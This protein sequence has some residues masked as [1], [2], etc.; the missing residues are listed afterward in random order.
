[1][2]LSL[3]SLLCVALIGFASHR[4]SLCNVRAVVELMCCRSAFMLGCMARAMLWMAALASALVWLFDAPTA[5][6]LTQRSLFW[7]F[8][9]GL[10]F[11]VGAAVNGGCSLSSL[12]RLVNGELGMLLTLGGFAAGVGLWTFFSP[13][14]PTAALV[15]APS[16]W[17]QA[18]PLAPWAP[19]ALAAWALFEA[20]RLWKL[21]RSSAAVSWRERL[22][23][24]SYHLSVAA[25]LLGLS[26]GFLYA[27]EGAWSYTNYLRGTMG[28]LLGQ[29]PAPTPWHG[30]LVAALLL[31]MWLSAAQRRA[32]ALQPPRDLGQALRHL[33]AGLLMGAGAALIPG[34]NDTL[35]L[36]SL[37]TLS[38]SAASAYGAML[39]TIAAT[40]RLQQAL[41]LPLPELRCSPAG[42][43]ESA[44]PSPPR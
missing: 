16:P 24:P 18:G 28:H 21:A 31:G 22:L 34:G 4:A 35:L 41:G 37:P 10:L 39:L 33:L 38:L 40:L 7:A 32:I 12:H 43:V 1:M 20:R 3:V 14:A 5:V 13:A 17:R 26:G 29:S 30:L 27:V 6:V 8:L 44:A 9:G 36:S 25:I 42:C 2:L 15:P 23:S 19:T 11:G